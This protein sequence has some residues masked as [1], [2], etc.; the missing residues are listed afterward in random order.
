[1]FVTNFLYDISELFMT[2]NEELKFPRNMSN[3][4]KKHTDQTKTQEERKSS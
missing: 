3:P 1:M 2:V 4:I